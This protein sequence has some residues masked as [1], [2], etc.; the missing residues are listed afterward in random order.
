M[1]DKNDIVH[2]KER[3]SVQTGT[4]KTVYSFTER[5][6]G[7]AVKKQVSCQENVQIEG[8]G[9]G[10]R[11]RERSAEAPVYSTQRHTLRVSQSG[12]SPSCC[13]PLPENSW[14]NV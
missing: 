11:Q 2:I 4:P 14:L 3:G 9:E 6:D 8:E 13:S 7:I 10:E 1:H 12:R 5:P